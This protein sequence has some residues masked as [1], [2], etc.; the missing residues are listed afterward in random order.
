MLLIFMQHKYVVGRWGARGRGEASN[1]VILSNICR[2]KHNFVHITFVAT[3]L[4]L[5]RQ[6]RNC[7][8]KTFVTTKM[9]L[10]AAPANDRVS[11]LN[12]VGLPFTSEEQKRVDS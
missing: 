3:S 8:D 10:V 2:D 6:T 9:I 4:L 1:F 11:A 7:R 5:S 12:H